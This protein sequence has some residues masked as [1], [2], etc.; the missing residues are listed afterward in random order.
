MYVDDMYG[1]G[2]HGPRNE[3][4]RGAKSSRSEPRLEY[5]RK[6][7]KLSGDGHETPRLREKRKKGKK[8]ETRRKKKR[9]RSRCIEGG[10]AKPK[11]KEK[12]KVFVNGGVPWG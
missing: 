10:D 3:E 5:L 12:H 9:K 1:I 11:I 6:K 2:L 7:V 8:G 4:K